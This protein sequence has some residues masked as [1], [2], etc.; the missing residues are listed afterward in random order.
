MLFSG[1]VPWQ[2][3][4][5][6]QTGFSLPEKK[7]CWRKEATELKRTGWGAGGIIL[8]LITVKWRGPPGAE[9]PYGLFLKSSVD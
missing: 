1:V 7:K 3:G 4:G 8:L 6:Q 5:G 9:V 2:H